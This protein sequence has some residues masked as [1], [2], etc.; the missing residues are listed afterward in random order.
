MR[1]YYLN[2]KINFVSLGNNKNTFQFIWF[3]QNLG[4]E[5]TV[6]GGTRIIDINYCS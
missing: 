1:P 5:Y 4:Q 2:C 3:C 6:V